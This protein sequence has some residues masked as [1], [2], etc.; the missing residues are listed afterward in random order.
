MFQR[1]ILTADKAANNAAFLENVRGYLVKELPAMTNLANFSALVAHF[2]PNINWAGFYLYDGTKLVLG[3][4]QGLPA[5]TII[6]LDR[7]VCGHAATHRKTIIVPD[8]HAFP[9]H[10]ACDAAS[11][12]EIVI[13]ILQANSLFGVLDLDSPDLD[14]FDQI[15]ADTLEKAVGILVDNL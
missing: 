2:F 5:C 12:S 9:G 15:D 4:F 10:I 14:R 3:P 7:G 13:P 11:R 6:T 8:T 1:H